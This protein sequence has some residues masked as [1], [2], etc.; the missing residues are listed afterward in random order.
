[1][2]YFWIPINKNKHTNINKQRERERKKGEGKKPAHMNGS[3]GSRI[4]KC[5]FTHC[6]T[7]LLLGTT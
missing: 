1:M 5:L 4:A 3:F 7:N 6:S 2:C